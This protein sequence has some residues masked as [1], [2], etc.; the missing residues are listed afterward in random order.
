MYHY[1]KGWLKNKLKHHHYLPK[2][3]QNKTTKNH[4]NRIMPNSTQCQTITT[5]R[6]KPLSSSK[7]GT[8]TGMMLIIS[9]F[10]YLNI[11][12]RII[13]H[14]AQK[15]PLWGREKAKSNKNHSGLFPP[16]PGS[17]GDS[18]LRQVWQ[19]YNLC[20]SNVITCHGILLLTFIELVFLEM[21]QKI[22]MAHKTLH[23][24]KEN[25]IN[26]IFTTEIRSCGLSIKNTLFSKQ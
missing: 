26:F 22:E 23:P 15:T 20:Y 9:V 12:E 4:S 7:A 19:L 17:F 1:R 5:L 8:V 25:T 13:R 21:E 16:R 3:P 14:G 11:L 6:R 2:K 24:S 10:I 18:G